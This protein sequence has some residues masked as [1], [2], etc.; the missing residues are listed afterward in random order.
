M[1][2]SLLRARCV[3]MAAVGV[4][5]ILFASSALAAGLERNGGGGRHGG[6]MGG[7]AGGMHGGGAM[8]N[9]G[10]TFG[11]GGVN[12]QR[13]G[14]NG[15]GMATRGG[16]WRGGYGGGYQYGGAALGLGLLGGAIIGSQYPFYDSNDGYGAGYEYDRQDTDGSYCANRFRSFDPVS[17]TYLGYDGLRHPCP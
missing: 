6:G 3:S 1:R 14:W 4:G 2:R 13:G 11:G 10:R 5:L 15:G 9:G 16:G 8:R 7:H 12:G 17:G